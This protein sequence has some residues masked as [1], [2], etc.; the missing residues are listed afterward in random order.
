MGNTYKCFPGRAALVV[1]DPTNWL[2]NGIVHTGQALP[3]GGRHRILRR[4][5]ERAHTA[6]I[7]VLFHSPVVCGTTH[8]RDFA[9]AVYYTT[10]SGAG[11]FGKWH[12]R[13][14][15]CGMDPYC[16]G[17]PQTGHAAPLSS[18]Q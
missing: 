17:P 5:S 2:L 14:W 13:D 7:E 16:T 1:A 9:D 3:G 18:T 6:S 15:V 8:Q 4:R 12:P 11:V 10:P